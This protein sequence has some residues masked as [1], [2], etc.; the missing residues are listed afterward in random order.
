MPRAAEKQHRSGKIGCRGRRP[1]ASYRPAMASP[2]GKSARRELIAKVEANHRE[3]E[4]VNGHALRSGAERL[5]SAE[6]IARRNRGVASELCRRRADQ[7]RTVPTCLQTRSAPAVRVAAS[8][9]AHSRLTRAAII[10]NAFG[11]GKRRGL[12]WGESSGCACT[13]E[14]EA[15]AT[16]PIPSSPAAPPRNTSSRPR[17]VSGRSA[18]RQRHGCTGKLCRFDGPWQGAS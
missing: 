10:T 9:I 2:H 17:L 6:L 1:G 8:T 4:F 15:Q 11:F 7:S 5:R 16:I 14:C 3:I 18:A 12:P 13:H